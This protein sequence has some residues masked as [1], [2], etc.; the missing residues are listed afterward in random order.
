[1]TRKIVVIIYSIVVCNLF[2]YTNWCDSS[3]NNGTVL[4]TN[5]KTWKHPTKKVFE[6]YKIEVEKMELKNDGKY[7]VFLR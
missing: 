5:V 6:K 3:Y 2:I 4:I 7:H 1:M